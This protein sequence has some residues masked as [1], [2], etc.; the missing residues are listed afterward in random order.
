MAYND[1]GTGLLRTVNFAFDERVTGKILT[2]AHQGDVAGIAIPSFFDELEGG[3]PIAAPS[4][5]QI[6]GSYNEL[7]VSVIPIPSAHTDK[8]QIVF[9]YPGR[10]T[11]TY[12]VIA[13]GLTEE[14]A[15]QYTLDNQYDVSGPTGNRTVRQKYTRTIE[16]P[17]SNYTV[18]E[19][20]WSYFLS[21]AWPEVEQPFNVSSSEGGSFDFCGSFWNENWDAVTTSPSVRP[22]SWIHNVVVENYAGAIWRKGVIRVE[23][24][25]QL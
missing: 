12:R 8:I 7:E 21:N 2:Y 4:I 9:T 5:R 25:F 3:Y 17:T 20:E 18:A 13:T 22:F 11:A 16:F 23:N 14:Q 1:I 15:E 6:G 24:F 10:K 19:I